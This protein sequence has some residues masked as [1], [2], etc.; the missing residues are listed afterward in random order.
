MMTVAALFTAPVLPQARQRS[1]DLPI[2]GIVG[3]TGKL[4]RSSDFYSAHGHG[5]DVNQ[6]KASSSSANNQK[7]VANPRRRSATPS[8]PLERVDFPKLT[9]AGIVVGMMSGSQLEIYV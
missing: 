9:T 2:D 6:G 1:N 7:R 3:Q 5:T 4:A 8:F